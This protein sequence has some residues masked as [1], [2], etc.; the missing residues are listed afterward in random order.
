[1]AT[2]AVAP[3]RSPRRRLPMPPRPSSFSS[4]NRSLSVVPVPITVGPPP[5]FRLHRRLP[6]MT[7]DPEHAA[8][9]DAHGSP[10]HDASGTP[11]SQ[12]R[13]DHRTGPRP[14]RTSTAALAGADRASRGV[15]GSGRRSGPRGRRWRRDS[16]RG[17]RWRVGRCRAGRGR[18][19]AG[20]RRAEPCEP[21]ASRRSA[22]RPRGRTVAHRSRPVVVAGRR[23]AGYRADGDARRPGRRSAGSARL[24]I[25]RTVGSASRPSGAA[26]GGLGGPATSG[27][28]SG[29]GGSMYDG[30]RSSGGGTRITAPTNRSS[31]LLNLSGVGLGERR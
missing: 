30:S 16:V 7:L 15:R 12:S 5:S 10:S 9:R 21:A 13:G 17:S 8:R 20:S 11:A 23:T 6:E 22:R 31:G 14:G 25:A 4:R 26:A 28:T 1:M 19:S 27:R 3:G 29:A 18:S 24:R 2:G